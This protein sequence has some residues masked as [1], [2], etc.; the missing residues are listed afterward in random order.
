MTIDNRGALIAHVEAGESFDYLPFWGH[1]QKSPERV[2]AS[3]LSQWFPAAFTIDGIRYATAEHWMM[4]SKA[5]LFGDDASLTKILAAAT[6]EVA[7]KL[8]R[9]VQNFDE[10]RWSNARFELVVRGN[11]A[12]FGQHDLLRV[13]L[14]ATGTQVLV[15]ASP[16][17]TIWGI[18]LGRDNP[19]ARDPRTW[20]G[21]NLLGFALMAVREKLKA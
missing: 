6:P 13:F 2:D 1:T 20:R 15:E 12:K 16:R 18:G 5:R 11:E 8:G 4:A 17:D 14:L 3:C 7:K 10:A 19:K 9:G 21:Q